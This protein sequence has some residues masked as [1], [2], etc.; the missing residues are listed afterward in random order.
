MS[1]RRRSG[2]DGSTRNLSVMKAL[3]I[4]EFLAN[5]N[6]TP[7]RMC[8]IAAALGMNVS[9][10]SRFLSS[11]AARGYV[12]ADSDSG[13]YC[14]SLKFCTI[15][16]SVN[17]NSQLYSLALPVMRE[18]SRTVNESVCLAVEQNAMVE[19]IGV[20]PAAGQMMQTL[21][22]IGNRAPMH[23]TGIG[24]L[25]L[26]GHSPEEIDQIL[27]EKGMTAFTPHTIADRELLFRE[28]DR[29]RERGYA[30]DNEECEIGARC[31]AFPIYSPGGQLM[32]GISVTGPIF[33]LTD[34]KIRS[35]LPYL[36]AQAQ[37]IS[38]MLAV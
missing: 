20:V 25:L 3:D 31:I 4:I 22:R 21:Q 26:C 12:R 8:D 14:L 28:L 38:E 15:A 24:K 19:Y 16:D 1:I 27:E 2:P 33:R 5:E 30:F 37:R 11:L 35:A 34:E 7:Q 10:V 36:T 6:N 23:C 9:T 17:R 29:V 32:A 13:R 18:I